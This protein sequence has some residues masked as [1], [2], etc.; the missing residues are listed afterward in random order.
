MAI[1]DDF[2]VNSAGDIRHVA[3]TTT[4]TVLELHRWLQDLADDAAAAGDD[5]IDITSDTPSERSTDQIITLNS[6]Y[7]IDDVAAEYLYGGSIEQA[8]GDTLYAGLTVVGSVFSSTTLQIVQDNALYDTDTP[9][10]GA[11]L[12]DDPANNILLRIIVKVRDAGSDVDGKRIRVFAREWGDTYAE[13][14]VTMGLGVSTAAIFTSEDLNNTTLVGDL[15][16]WDQFSNTEGYQLIDLGNGNG[17]QPYYSQWDIGGGSTPSS[18]SINDLYEWAKYLTRRGTSQTLYGMDGELFRGITHEW[19][20]DNESGGPFSQNEEL[21]WTG[22]T[23]ALLAIDDQGSTGT[24]WIQLLTGSA[25]SDGATV[26]GGTSAATADVNGTVTSRTLP[27]VFLGQ[28]T[29][30][31]IIGGF[32]VGIASEDLTQNDKLFDLTNT[33][34][35]PPNNVTFT[36]F[37]LVSG[38]DRVLVTK[39]DGTVGIDSAQMTLATTLSGG[40]E[41]QVDVGS[42]NIP[43]DTPDTGV[44]RIVLDDGRHRRVPYSS[45]DSSQYFTISSTDFT[46][47]NDATAGNGV[48]LG[49]VDKL[50]AGSSESFTVVYNADRTLFIR[51]RDGGASPIKTFETTGTLGTAG[52]S[53]TAIRTSDE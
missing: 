52:G 49:Y 13:F 19:N 26:T 11:G 44:L 17:D 22:G 30:S 8:G 29:G 24:M 5:L 34:Q 35:V 31:A 38:E 45:H 7:N 15:G 33:Q 6:P 50:A 36:V 28:S 1:G 37:G 41:T 9:F 53:T 14:E 18:P 3:G 27:S 51:V 20:Y 47:P 4:Y 48:Y 23:G 21:S 46:D 43:A 10:W 39:D 16:S 25:P 42:G 40:T 12:N 32:G 2:S